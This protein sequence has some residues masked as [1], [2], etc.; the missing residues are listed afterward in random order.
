MRDSTPPNSLRT[1]YFSSWH[2]Y[3][4]LAIDVLM[5]LDAQH[6][7]AGYER[8]AL[9]VA[10]RGRARFLLD[11][12]EESGSRDPAGRTAICGHGR[13]KACAASIWRKA[14]WLRCEPRIRI[15]HRRLVWSREVAS[16][17]E[18]ED[19]LEAEMSRSGAVALIGLGG[20]LSCSRRSRFRR[21]QR[22]L[23]GRNAALEYWTNDD[24][25][26]LWVVTAD[27][28]HAYRLPGADAAE[29]SGATVD[30]RP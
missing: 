25:S 21:L 20:A 23:G 2:S 12:M 27:S 26:Y 6:P 5:H 13:R 16:L 9:V 1:G 10:E 15:P 8:Q 30:A 7:G 28:L 22:N 24:A 18:R 19:R 29:P 4:A 11:Q 3:Y 17:M 14:A